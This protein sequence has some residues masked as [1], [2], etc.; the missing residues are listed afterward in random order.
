MLNDSCGN[1]HIYY[2]SNLMEMSLEAVCNC[3]IFSKFSSVE[4]FSRSEVFFKKTKKLK[5][6]TFMVN[7]NQKYGI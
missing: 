1:R 7:M 3:I 5:K 2:V 4:S 6:K